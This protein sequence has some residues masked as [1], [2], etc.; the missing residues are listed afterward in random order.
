MQLSRIELLAIYWIV[1]TAAVA[2][3]WFLGVAVFG[4]QLGLLLTTI[5]CGGAL[6]VVVKRTW[7]F[8]Q[9]Q[10]IEYQ[11]I[12]FVLAWG[13]LFTG[14]LQSRMLEQKIDGWYSGG[15][16]WGDL[17]LHTSFISKFAN[18]LELDLTSPIYAQEETRYPFLFDFYTAQFVRLGI[19]IQHALVYT[20]LGLLVAS[21]VLF[22]RIVFVLIKSARG[23]WIAS[24]L[25]FLNGGLGFWYFFSD[26]FAGKK[27]LQNYSHIIDHGIHFSNVI[28]DLLLP[29]RGIILGL[30]LF[31]VALTI[32]QQA[33]NNL[34]RW[35]LSSLLIGLTPLIHVHTFLVLLGCLGW[36]LFVKRL[37]KEITTKQLLLAVLP[38]MILGMTQLWWMGASE[39]GAHF[40]KSIRGWMEP[41]EFIGWFWFKNL[42]L[43][44]FFL[45]LGNAFIFWKTKQRTVLHLLLPPLLVVFVL[46]NVIS[47]Q[48]YIYDNIK[49]FFYIHFFTALFT[50]VLLLQLARYS[51]LA[52]ATC[53]ALLT[54][55]GT[56]SIIRQN[57][58]S[59]R[60]A[61]SDELAFAKQ[62]RATTASTA[63]FLTADNHNHPIPMLAGRSTVLG[64]RG[65]LWTH[66]VDYQETESEVRS[67]FAGDQDA[68]ALLK[69]HNISYVVLGDEERQQ[70]EVDEAFFAQHFPILLQLK[71]KTVYSVQ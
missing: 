24:C 67:I 25:F 58:V 69:K 33:K 4:Y 28:T 37:Q 34:Q 15:G 52:A 5:L 55:T 6:S 8:T 44:L 70:Y 31:L 20:S 22:Y 1:G 3:F 39:Q 59:W 54:L 27:I 57:Q 35:V 48:P 16:T 38:A 64:Y 12:I 49:I 60:L 71:N 53:F 11:Q 56:L 51:R 68:E 62:A 41:K 40:I 63:V 47:L 17:A 42:G 14:L 9:H 29:Q 46:G 2:W 10:P 65:W 30:A 19:S 13:I 23:V 45:T 18:Q 66:G 32:W 61:S 21:L 7:R 36:L 26:F 50:T 43:E